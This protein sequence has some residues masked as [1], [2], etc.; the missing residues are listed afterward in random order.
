M[1]ANE[2]DIEL[3]RQASLLHDIGK[4]GIP[5]SVLTKTTRL[6][7]DEYEIMKRHV[8]LSVTIIKYLPTFNKVI[9]SV[10]GHHERYDGNGY[11]RQL[12]GENIPFG[13]RCI[14][15]ADAFDAITS[16]RHYKMN[17]TI[18]YALQEI[19]RNS[20]SQ[21]DPKMADA[22]I[23]LIDAGQIIVEPTRSFTQ[24]DIESVN[25]PS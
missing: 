3:I 5:E 25:R 18:D 12:K 16:D 11:P 15:L 21:F 4:I 24:A 1:G 23:R 8:D 13:A 20:G 9:P 2:A 10:I 22:F 6:T 17:M 14:A 19:R 7:Q